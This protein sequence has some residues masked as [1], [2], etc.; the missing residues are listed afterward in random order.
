MK[1]QWNLKPKANEQLVTELQ[2]SLGVAKI[3]AELLVQ[4]GITTFETAKTFFRPDLR[5]LHD[6]FL[7]KD[8]DSAVAV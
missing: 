4:R 7:M 1:K 5:H 6:P 8:M 2:E 3:V